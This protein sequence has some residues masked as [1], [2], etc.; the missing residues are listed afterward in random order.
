MLIPAMR[1]LQPTTPSRPKALYLGGLDVIATGV[2]NSYGVEPESITVVEAGPGQVSSMEFTIVDPA[3]QIA[4]VDGMDVRYEDTIL[5]MPI[6]RGWVAPFGVSRFGV[7]RAIKVKCIG[8]EAVLDWLYVPALTIAAGGPGGAWPWQ[9]IVAQAIGNGYPLNVAA[10]PIGGQSSVAHPVESYGGGSTG[11]ITIPAGTLRQAL[12]AFSDG[13]FAQGNPA[14][15]S[16]IHVDMWGGLRVQVWSI[17]PPF[18]NAF[19]DYAIATVSGSPIAPSGTQWGYNASGTP[20]AVWI[21]GSGAGTGLVS[22][23]SAIPGPVAV[24]SDAN[25]T[26][27]ARRVAIGRAYLQGQ[28]AALTGSVVVEGGLTMGSVGA[29]VRPPTLL[30]LTDAQVGITPATDFRIRSITKTWAPSGLERWVIA[31]GGPEP[32]GAQYLRTL[33]N[34]RLV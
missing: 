5:G 17:D 16:L 30:R 27:A 31:F 3:G 14:F 10:D 23:G 11:P 33:T 9:S 34:D 28:A 12:Q 6:F 7:G 19:D 24:I 18:A 32:R 25:S 4:I 21:N 29:Q 8:I 13:L 26:D 15:T 22:D 1:H 2:P 20:R